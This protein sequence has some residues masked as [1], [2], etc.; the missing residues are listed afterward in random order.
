[1][2][3]EQFGSEIYNARHSQNLLEQIHLDPNRIICQW[4]AFNVS[5]FDLVAID[6][7][8]GRI[9]RIIA[10]RKAASSSFAETTTDAFRR[11]A[12]INSKDPINSVMA[13]NLSAGPDVPVWFDISDD[14]IVMKFEITKL[15]WYLL[16]H[17]VQPAIADAM[18][19]HLPIKGMPLDAAM[20]VF[21]TSVADTE[22]PGAVDDHVYEWKE[23]KTVKDRRARVTGTYSAD[24][25]YNQVQASILT[26]DTS[27]EELTR[28]ITARFVNGVCVDFEDDHYDK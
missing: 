4:I 18:R 21:G 22:N 16:Y 8:D 24:D 3:P 9:T 26:P 23:H 20:A 11:Y 2:L 14:G 28:D 15:E 25:Y 12:G 19:S 10:V 1:L 5:G 6:L 7:T 13:K 17:N 27:H